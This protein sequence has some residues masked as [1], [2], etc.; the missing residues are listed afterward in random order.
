M[1]GILGGV[2]LGWGLGANDAA[3][4]FGTAVGTRMLRFGIAAA[5]C[6]VFV[7][8]GA[9]L[10]GAGAAHGLGKLGAVNALP[11][12]FMVALSLSVGIRR[13]QTLLRHS[14]QIHRALRLPPPQI[15]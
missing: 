2:L 13:H 11:G 12:A 10:G 8:L 7:V 6:S 4:V 14:R 3:N 15:A 5:I 9:V 1:I